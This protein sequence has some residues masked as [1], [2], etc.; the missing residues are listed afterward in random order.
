MKKIAILI[1][2]AVAPIVSW[3][4]NAFDSFENE[5]DVTSVVVTKNM[6]KLL[7]KMDLN[8]SDPE[9]Q[10]YLKMVNELDNIKIFTTDNPGV[11]K[12]MEE[13]VAKYVS[14][15]KNLGELMRVK[16]DGKNIKFYSKEGKSENFVSELLMHLE[17]V[18]EG[19]QTT[20]IMSVTGNIDLKQISKLTADLK[21][22]GSEELKNIDKKKN[23]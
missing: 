20:V 22:P 23:K 14:G 1:A 8:S 2:L 7:S 6:F 10:A 3:S 5:K 11:S 17:G 19:K 16:E 21:V 4:Q 15:S 9:A 13:A 12:K 18:V